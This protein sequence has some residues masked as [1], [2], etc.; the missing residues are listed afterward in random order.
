MLYYRGDKFVKGKKFTINESIYKFVKKSRD[1]KL[2]FESIEDKSLLKITESEY[3][4]MLQEKINKD[5]AEINELI[6]KALRSK[7]EARKIEDRLAQYGIT[8]DYTKGQGVYLKGPNGKTL[9]ASVDKVT[10]P[11]RPGFNDTHRQ[12]RKFYASN[13]KDTK[14]RLDDLKNMSDE[15]KL[16]RFGVDARTGE[17]FT[18]KEALERYNKAVKS[19]EDTLKTLEKYRDEENRDI[20]AKRRAGHNTQID[21]SSLG[22]DETDR[23]HANKHIDY[24]TY[25]TKKPNEYQDAVRKSQYYGALKP[26]ATQSQK[27]ISKYNDL[28]RKVGNSQWEVDYKSKEADDKY[29]AMDD[30]EL[31][32]KIKEMRDNLEKQIEEL[33]KGNIEN[34]DELKYRKDNLNKAEKELDNFLKSKG[35]RESVR[36][37]IISKK[38]YE[39]AGLNNKDYYNKRL[40]RIYDDILDLAKEAEHDGYNELSKSLDNMLDI[41]DKISIK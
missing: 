15:D 31:E 19:T 9:S 7:S 39:E 25:L 32:A 14:A 36:N 37:K 23:E 22:A 20:K 8:V 5:N 30:D 27:D 12:N 26:D 35:V 1:N 3:N 28:R 24:L 2:I 11:S 21:N 34:Q 16:R 4:I 13:Y 6:G 33:R 29:R 40:D 18:D 10:G 17:R 41:L 38:L